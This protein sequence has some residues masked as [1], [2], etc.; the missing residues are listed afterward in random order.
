MPVLSNIMNFINIWKPLIEIVI[1]WS[2]F[3]HI[4][5]FF[6][7]TR[8]IQVLRGIIV[9]SVAFFLFQMLGFQILNWLLTKV[10][11]ISVIAILIIFHPEIR[12]GLARIGQRNIFGTVLREEE[13]DY[14]LKEIC[15]AAES[16]VK[17]KIGAL[18]AIEK[19]DPLTA[20]I[21]SGVMIDGRVSSDLIQSIFTPYNPLHDGG[22]IIQS[23]RIMAAGCIFPLTQNQYLSRIFG[24][25]HRAAIGLS[26]ETDAIVI[27]V[28]EER[29]DISLVYRGKL[30]KELTRESL[31]L[32]I[33]EIM[34]IKRE[35]EQTK[36]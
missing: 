16:L 29:H 2:V 14:M 7:G 34:K 20:Y 31:L 18:I 35:D 22:L 24:T 28:S 8:A 3:Y 30:Y 23:G 5:F 10:F 27:I 17:D 6:E 21:E 32:E 36:S 13:L 19:N 26:E 4:M 12:Q 15:K 25:R 1:L 9:L 11:A 33:K